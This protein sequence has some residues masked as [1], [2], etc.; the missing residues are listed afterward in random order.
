MAK[1]LIS[2]DKALQAIKPGDP[3][4]RISDGAGLYLLLFVKGGALGW[5]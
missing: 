4:K 1:E 5:R 2:G 3:R